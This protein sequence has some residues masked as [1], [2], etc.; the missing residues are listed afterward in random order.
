[1]RLMK[2]DGKEYLFY[3]SF[4]INVAIIRGTSADE[5]G[6]IS[7]EKEAIALE[8]LCLALAA[9]ACGGKVIVQVE[10]VVQAG[11]IHPMMVKV[12]RAVVDVIVIAKPEN[13]VQVSITEPFNP[14]L[15]GE[16]R[17]PVSEVHP[18][19][20]SQRKVICRRCAMELIP[21]AVVNLGL[22]TPEGV[23][24]VS[25]EEGISSLMNM[26][27]EPGV[28]GGVPLEGEYFGTA[29]NPEAMIDH[30]LMFDFYDGGGLDLAVLGMAEM[31]RF[32]NVNVSKF[33]PR[34]PGAGGF[35][36]ITQSAKTVIFCGTLTANGLKSEIADGRLKIL[37][38]GKVKKLVSKVEQITFSGEYGQTTG[39]KIL[40]VTERAVFEL[41]REGVTLIEIAP[42]ID[43]QNEVLD[44]MCFKPLI[45][46]D[47]KSMDPR[48]FRPEMPMGIRDEILAK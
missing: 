37:S 22:G 10:R 4:P 8:F 28:F 9:K 16:V 35:I 29:L 3:K 30:P 38:E 45:A 2:I 17:A 13:H 18:L 23:G 27:V 1:M 46:S 32:G 40:Y 6:N 15:C 5:K 19:P 12:P 34:S 47:L 26:T 24:V 14:A 36:N 31:D 48:I 20:F 39:Q 33:G 42:G 21:N 43:L 11:T 41:R 25:A 7:I 44:Q